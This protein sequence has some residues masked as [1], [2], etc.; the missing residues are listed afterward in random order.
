MLFSTDWLKAGVFVQLKK[1]TKKTDKKPNG[2]HPRSTSPHTSLLERLRAAEAKRVHTTI[3]DWNF[4]LCRC[5]LGASMNLKM[6]DR[7]RWTV[8]KVLTS[9]FVSDER[10]WVLIPATLCSI[11]ETLPAPLRLGEWGFGARLHRKGNFLGGSLSSGDTS[12]GFDMPDEVRQY[13]QTLFYGK[14]H[15]K[16][17]LKT[18]D[19]PCRTPAAVG[20]IA[21]P[22]TPAPPWKKKC[23]NVLM[24]LTRL[25]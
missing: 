14:W 11:F 10:R 2:R 6:W 21:S 1:Q 24:Q 5:V 8:G 19:A 18:S 4:P 20:F 13:Q 23:Q 25:R 22:L 3:R 12:G 9:I 16:E 7:W 15:Q 17:W